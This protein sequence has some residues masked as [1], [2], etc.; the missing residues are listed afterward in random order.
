MTDQS[1]KLLRAWK[2]SNVAAILAGI[3]LVV[4]LPL[5]VFW[6]LWDAVAVLITARYTRIVYRAFFYQEPRFDEL[7]T[8]AATGRALE[9]F[10]RGMWLLVIAAVLAVAAL[11]PAVFVTNPIWALETRA[12]DW[13]R[14]LTLTLPVL[15]V[16][17]LLLASHTILKASTA[18]LEG[19]KNNLTE[20]QLR[21][22]EEVRSS[23]LYCDTPARWCF[24]ILSIFVILLTL[25]ALIYTD[26]MDAFSVGIKPFISGAV[27]FQLIFSNYIYG[28]QF[29]S[30]GITAAVKR[31]ATGL[32]K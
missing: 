20:A 22:F 17:A 9:R 5:G 24:S 14:A 3:L 19:K 27:S 32:E 31:P 6:V 4:F 29:R 13:T 25:K 16:L 28:L 23:V 2:Q 15:H 7:L 21:P 30:M 18:M 11:K 1:N 10:R 26:Q 8:A 12:E